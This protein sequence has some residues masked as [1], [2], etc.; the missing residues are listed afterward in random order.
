M[1]GIGAS[2]SLRCRAE[3]HEEAAL[4]GF[5]IRSA[6]LGLHRIDSIA[7]SMPRQACLRARGDARA[8]G[9]CHQSGKQGI[10]IGQGVLVALKSAPF[11]KPHHPSRSSRHDA[12][13][14][15]GCG[16]RQWEEGAG[17]MGPPSIHS[18]EYD[19]VKVWCQIQS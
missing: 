18:I 16:R 6:L 13:H 15:L 1:G 11:K 9:G 19:A 8:N 10:V 7:K 12:S 4:G 14:V 17:G 2:R 3:L 5:C